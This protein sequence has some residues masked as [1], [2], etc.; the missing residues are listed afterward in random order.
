L[1]LD[2]VRLVDSGFGAETGPGLKKIEKIK[3]RGD[4]AT[5]MTRQDPV[6]NSVVT[7]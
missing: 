6:K 1:K 7:R 4:P 5:D 2:P 3:T